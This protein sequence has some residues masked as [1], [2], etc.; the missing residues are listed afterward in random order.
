[1]NIDTQKLIQ[2]LNEAQSDEAFKDIA[3][4]LKRLE[5]PADALWLKP[6][7][8]GLCYVLNSLLPLSDTRRDS[9]VMLAQAQA[10]RVKQ[11]T[12]KNAEAFVLEAFCLQAKIMVSSMIRGPLYIGSVEDALYAAIGLDKRNPRAYFLLGQTVL[13]KPSFMGGGKQKALP[14]LRKA[15]EEFQAQQP[16]TPLHPHWGEQQTRDLLAEIEAE[17]IS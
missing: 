8:L 9:L 13:H 1:M 11:Q 4:E 3:L 7:Y 10:T 6:Y 5:A 15:L 12:S 2:Q 17:A 16:K 14:I